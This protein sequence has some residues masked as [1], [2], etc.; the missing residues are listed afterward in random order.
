M[1]PTAPLRGLSLQ[2][3][4]EACALQVDSVDAVPA[5]LQRL[6]SEAQRLGSE[7]AQF[8]ALKESH[9]AL[10]DLNNRLARQLA[11][12]QRSP[13]ALSDSADHSTV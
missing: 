7:A 6:R 3:T 11:D 5:E 4:P 9:Q 2:L 12:P 1:R 8:P 13:S 10:L